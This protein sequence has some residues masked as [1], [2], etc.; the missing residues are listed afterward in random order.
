LFA[1]NPQKSSFFRV[2]NA[3]CAL[4]SLAQCRDET[5]G[6]AGAPTLDVYTYFGGPGSSA[7]NCTGVDTFHSFVGTCQGIYSSSGGT[8]KVFTCPF[9]S[10][11]Y[12]VVSVR[13]GEN[14]C[15]D[16]SVIP[17]A[18]FEESTQKCPTTGC[19]ISTGQSISTSCQGARLPSSVTSQF[20]ISL[21]SYSVGSGCNG[22]S[23]AAVYAQ[24]KTCL[25]LE[26]GRSMIFDCTA[27]TLTLYSFGGCSGSNTVTQLTPGCND[28]GTEYFSC[29]GSVASRTA[30]SFGL[31]FVVFLLAVL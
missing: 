18:I 22:E 1:V 9:E 6:T 25:P 8:R 24:D 5:G 13:P 12:K 15:S 23:T 11:G 21:L 4:N 26:N 31:M 10:S 16:N 29:P 14:S 7:S 28:K 30:V 19:Q 2:E 17:N 3:K 20:P 27:R